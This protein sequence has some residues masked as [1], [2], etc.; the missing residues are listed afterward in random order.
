MTALL[1]IGV[2]S[3]VL[4][5]TPALPYVVLSLTVLFLAFQQ[6]AISTVTWLMLSEIF[7][8]H[9]RGAWHGDQHLLLVDS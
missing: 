7:P 9:V 6:T 2:L 8:M 4:E 5:G 1:L 3:I